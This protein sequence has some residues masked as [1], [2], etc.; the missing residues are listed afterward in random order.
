M[1]ASDSCASPLDPLPRPPAPDAPALVPRP[2]PPEARS[3]PLRLRP[4]RPDQPPLPGMRHTR[5]R[6][7]AP[8]IAL[9]F[10]APSFAAVRQCAGLLRGRRGTVLLMSPAIEP[11][12]RVG[13]NPTRLLISLTKLG[14][15]YMLLIT[16]GAE[17]AACR[18]PLRG[19][20]PPAGASDQPPPGR[21]AV[22][23]RPRPC[24]FVT[25]SRWGP[26]FRAQFTRRGGSLRGFVASANALGL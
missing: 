10:V 24:R 19:H 9:P 8:L 6:A 2:P 15:C 14:K 20:E 26:P 25:L 1:T 3:L 11:P 13:R 4:H 16:T 7:A 21:S 5:P 18:Q 22:D 23:A 12:G 17:S